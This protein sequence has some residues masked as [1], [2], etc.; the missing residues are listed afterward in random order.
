ML[1]AR[2]MPSKEMILTHGGGCERS[3]IVLGD[4]LRWLS[5]RRKACP[6]IAK[7]LVVGGRPLRLSEFWKWVRVSTPYNHV[8]T[9]R[10]DPTPSDSQ[11][12]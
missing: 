10:Q 7:S 4:L 3:S 5:K 11:H 12:E 9:D 1:A 6:G 2:V 8:T